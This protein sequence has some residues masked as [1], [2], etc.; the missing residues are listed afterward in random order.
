ME[1]NRA[2]VYRLYPTNEQSRIV[3]IRRD[4]IHKQTT[5]LAKN[6]GLVVVENLRVKS[7]SASARGTEDQPGRNVRQKAGLKR[8]ILDAGWYTFRAILSYK[9]EE[10]G[11]YLLAVDPAYTSQT[12]SECRVV[13]RESRR[14][15]AEFLCTSCGHTDNADINA[16][17]NILRQGLPS[18]PVEGR[19]YAPEEAGSSPVRAA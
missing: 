17:R 2:N 18:M 10:R 12:C 19:G 3:A 16:A 8:S 5:A 1:Q 9:L 11:G 7:M 13:D 4:W 6:H 14:T 15:R